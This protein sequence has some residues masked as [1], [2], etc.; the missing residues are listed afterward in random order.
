MEAEGSID[1][2]TS[3]LN[4]SGSSKP[5]KRRVCADKAIVLQAYL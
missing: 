4:A 5:K 1:Q 2:E 3:D